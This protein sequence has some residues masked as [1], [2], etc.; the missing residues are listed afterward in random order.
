MKTTINKT[1]TGVAC[2]YFDEWAETSHI[3]WVEI[4][5]QE[6]FIAYIVDKDAVMS[7]PILSPYLVDLQMAFKDNPSFDSITL[8]LTQL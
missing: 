1:L 4:F 8:N 6:D 2:Q 3:P 5:S 7:C